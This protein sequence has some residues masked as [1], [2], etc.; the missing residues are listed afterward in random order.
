M[1]YELKTSESE[2]C[3]CHSGSEA[4][5][6]T[7]G[8]HH[9]GA[10]VA[11]CTSAKR[12]PLTL[13]SGVCS[14]A[15]EDADLTVLY[16]GVPCISF[17]EERKSPFNNPAEVLRSIA[18]VALS[19]FGVWTSAGLK[20]QSAEPPFWRRTIAEPLFRLFGGVAD[21]RRNPT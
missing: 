21:R 9:E 4:N 20:V 7:H 18:A 3:V 14:L 15:D 11:H 6:V 2:A 1:A 19:D 5:L 12:A 16:P 17:S 8:C 10:R 13:G